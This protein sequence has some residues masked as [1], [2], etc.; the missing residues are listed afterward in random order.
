MHAIVYNN[1]M[2]N[3]HYIQTFSMQPHHL[4]IELNAQ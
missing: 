4:F 2:H 3:P 1:S